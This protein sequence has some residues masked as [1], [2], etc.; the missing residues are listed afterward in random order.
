MEIPFTQ[1]STSARKRSGHDE[2]LGRA[3]LYWIPHKW[4]SLSGEYLYESFENP[5]ENTTTEEL[6][7]VDT[8]RLSFG[9]NFF[10]PSGLI[11][12]LKFTYVN[13]RGFFENV[14][15]V[16]Q[17]GE[18]EFTVVDAFL[19]YRLPKRYG[20]ITFGVKNLFD[21]GFNFQD[22]DSEN[23]SISPDQLFFGKATI[24]F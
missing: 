11:A 12:N 16:I 13:Q 5:K 17:G 1:V 14:D 18:D 2:D 8:H 21:K 4:F 22:T 20:I 19:S 7:K 10:H 9:T 6:T 24:S 3:Y 15:E 23:P